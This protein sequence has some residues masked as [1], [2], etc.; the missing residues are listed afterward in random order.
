MTDDKC[1]LVRA[2]GDLGDYLVSLSHTDARLRNDKRL[3]V[4]VEE[5]HAAV[6]VAKG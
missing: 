3:H 5:L 1:G 4:F 6:L 2:A